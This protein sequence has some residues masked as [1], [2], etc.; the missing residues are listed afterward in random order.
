MSNALS[1]TQKI[2]YDSTGLD[3][4]RVQEIVNREL[5]GCDEGE[6]Y[7]ES[8]VH[9]GYTLR[10]RK[11]FAAHSVSQ[12]FG[13]RYTAGEKTA[14]RSSS[15]LSETTILDAARIVRA[16]RGQGE[17][18]VSVAH[19]DI[20]VPAPALQSLYMSD[21]PMLGFSEKDKVKLLRD[22]NKYL[23]DKDKRVAEVTASLSFD[24]KCVEIIRPDRGPV[25]DIRPLIRMNVGAIVKDGSRR[26]S[27]GYGMGG[28]I[29]CSAFFNE[30]A[31]KYAAD[32]ALD[33]A[34][35]MLRA[36]PAPAGTM[37]VVVGAGW[38]GV[39]LHEA[40]GHG[41]EGDFNRK[42]TSNFSGRIGQRVAAKG[43]TVIDQ[44]NIPDR[45]GSLN[46][47]DEGNPTG[48]TVL[49]E[50][51]ILVGYMQDRMNARLMNMPVTGN[52]RRE[53]YRSVPMPRM[54]NT[55]AEDGPYSEEEIIASVKDGLYA[56]DFGGGSVDITSGKFNFE[57]AAAYPIKDGQVLWEEPVKG[58]TLI[59]NGPDVMG[60]ISMV[61]NNMRLDDGVGTCGKEGQGVPVGI[62][63][64]SFRIDGIT[65]GGRSTGPS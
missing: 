49:I 9:E 32:Q 34:L 38:P 39:L 14:Y 43:V 46:I 11:V 36:R 23:R 47:D 13:I 29:D 40:V 51:G 8:E 56:P 12:G 64:P 16:I 58:A 45:R 1:L 60:K 19:S 6:L 50:D 26:E 55:Y 25:A 48:R 18:T 30:A 52:G 44:G 65:V 7:L 21:N 20:I 28:R 59:G 2:F 24:Y 63:Q 33:K 41:L 27:G 3:R 17:G 4:V 15:N 42:G 10:E 31:W 5:Q 61:G 22:I 54:T 53:D 57:M 62:G 35:L 37:T